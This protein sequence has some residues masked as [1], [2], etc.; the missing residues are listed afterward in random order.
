MPHYVASE[1]EAEQTLAKIMSDPDTG[2]VIIDERI[3]RRIDDEKMRET[4][5]RWR[6]ILL[7]LPS[8]VKSSEVEDYA[9]RLIRRAVGY[10][11]RLQL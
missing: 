5:G 3:I 8:P 6:G 2:L 1:E 10:H 11:V 9:T 7:V 4:E